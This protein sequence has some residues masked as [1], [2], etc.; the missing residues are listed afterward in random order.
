MIDSLYDYYIVILWSVF[1]MHNV[2]ET[3]CLG[4]GG[5]EEQSYSA[6]FFRN[7]IR[8]RRKY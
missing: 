3:V 5:G 2:S 8:Q 1:D 4:G 6:G 7:T